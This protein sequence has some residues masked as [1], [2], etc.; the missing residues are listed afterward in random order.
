[1]IERGTFVN[2]QDFI[3]QNEQALKNYVKMSTVPGARVDYVQGGGGNTSVKLAGGLMAIKASGFKLSDITTDNAYAVVDVEAVRAFYQNHS[4]QEF[5]D[6]EKAGSDAVKAATVQVEG[7]PALRPSVETGFHA[8]LSTYVLHTHAAYG[9]LVTCCKEG[10]EI[11]EKVMRGIP[12]SYGFVPYTNPGAKLTFVIADEVKRVQRETG[13]KPAVIFM[14]NHGIIATCDSADDCIKL[15]D[16]VN[17]LCAKAFGISRADFPEIALRQEGDAFYSNT[18]WLKK[19]LAGSAF[20]IQDFVDDSL[21]PD[22]MVFLAGN[23]AIN[24]TGFSD[25]TCTINQKTGDVRY[26]CGQAEAQ[27]IEETLTVVLFIK[28]TIAK[29]G[30]TV[31]TMDSAGKDFIANWESEKYRKSMVQK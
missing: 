5:D 8:V 30:Y 28:E 15:H 12:Q 31:C 13:K 20:T 9:N 23:L 16:D 27:T 18:P 25:F 6:V 22:Q 26:T 11:A 2:K 1:M 14:Q 19:A 3:A 7:L 21:Y 29:N 4:A 10:R 17:D 24:D